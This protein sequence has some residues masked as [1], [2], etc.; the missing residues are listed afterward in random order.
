MKGF[1]YIV[2][3]VSL[4]CYG[5]PL[6]TDVTDQSGIDHGFIVF[7]GTFGGG[8]AVLDFDKD[9]FEDVFIAGGHNDGNKLYKNKGDGTFMDVSELFG[10]VFS[11]VITQGATTADVNRDGYPDLF[12]TTIVSLDGEGFEETRNYLLINRGGTSFEDQ[13]VEFGLVEEAF[14]TGA[15]FG[16]VNRDGYPDLYVC[17]YFEDFEGKLDQYSGLSSLN[18]T[19]GPSRDLLYIN[20]RGEKFVEASKIYG[21]EHIG[22]GFQSVWTDYDNDNDLDLYVVNDFG[23]R[24]HPNYFYRNDYPEKHFTEIGPQIGLRMGMSAMGIG[25]SDFNQDGWMDY[26]VSN[27]QISPFFVNQGKDRR[28]KQSSQALGTAFNFVTD[29]WG[30]SGPVVSWGINFFDVDLDMDEDVY[31]TNGCLNPSMASNANLLLINSGGQFEDFGYFSRTNDHSIGRGSVV[32]DYDNDGDLDLLVVN[33]LPHKED[34]FGFSFT[35]TRLFRNDNRRNNW[36]KVRLEGVISETNGIG[37]RVE[38]YVD[39]KVLIREVSG[40]SSHESQSSTI[41]HFGLGANT[42][43]DSLVVKWSAG[44]AERTNNIQ[45]N[46]LINIKE[47]YVPPTTSSPKE[48]LLYPNPVEEDFNITFNDEDIITVSA[49]E[50]IDSLGNLVTTYSVDKEVIDFLNFPLSI[51]LPTGLYY[52]RITSDAGVYFKKMIKK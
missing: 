19:N 45:A 14:S 43:V 34:T 40:G 28:F 41:V 15:S 32:F 42:V 39:G 50:I 47:T 46:Q 49:I 30:R 2:I 6:F 16:D 9:G 31:I 5:Q 17:N 1:F 18:N 38:V 44:I 20:V 51:G 29:N 7:D 35:G 25:V 26:L 21:I 8:A 22:L 36:L 52:L 12:V 3:F 4:H 13:S 10:D 48:I 11:R 33:Q 27:I 37:S 23:T 24:G